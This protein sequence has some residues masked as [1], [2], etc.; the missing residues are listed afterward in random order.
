MRVLKQA[1]SVR[2]AVSRSRANRDH[3]NLIVY[4]GQ[5]VPDLYPRELFA[6]CLRRHLEGPYRSTIWV[7]QRQRAGVRIDAHHPPVLDRLCRSDPR[8]P[9]ARA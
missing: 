7:D 3:Q 1:A 8:R 4:G 2:R 5:A 9:F 6:P